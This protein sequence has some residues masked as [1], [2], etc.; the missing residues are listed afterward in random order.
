MQFYLR[1]DGGLLNMNGKKKQ[2]LSQ[3]FDYSK[4]KNKPQWTSL[5][6]FRAAV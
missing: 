5:C 1:R 6:I 2:G 3:N 4:K